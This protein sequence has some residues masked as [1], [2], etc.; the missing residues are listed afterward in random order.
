LNS[1]NA[2]QTLKHQNTTCQTTP[3]NDYSKHQPTNQPTGKRIDR[4]TYRPGREARGV[5]AA[6]TGDEPRRPHANLAHRE[7]QQ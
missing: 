5:A 2:A 1:P 3:A 7:W 4:P 6:S